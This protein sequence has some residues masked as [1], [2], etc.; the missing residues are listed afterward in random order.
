MSVGRLLV[1]GGVCT[2]CNVRE[3]RV[4]VCVCGVRTC[5]CM[6]IRGAFILLLHCW[7]G[8]PKTKVRVWRARGP[9]VPRQRRR[10]S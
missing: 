5:V 2:R 10:V 9:R 6:L 4:C 1:I 7:L 8:T 3:M